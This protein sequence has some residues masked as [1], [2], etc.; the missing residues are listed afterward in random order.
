MRPGQQGLIHLEWTQLPLVP[1]L[2]CQWRNFTSCSEWVRVSCVIRHARSWV[3]KHFHVEFIPAPLPFC[4]G[5]SLWSYYWSS[6]N[7]IEPKGTDVRAV[8][9]IHNARVS[10]ELN[11]TPLSSNEWDYVL[12]RRHSYSLYGLHC[13]SLSPHTFL[14]LF[15]Q[16]KLFASLRKISGEH[17]IVIF[18]KKMYWHFSKYI[19]WEDSKQCLQKHFQSPQA[20]AEIS[21]LGR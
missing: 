14:V 15:S 1:S 17:H 7:L 6:L 16:F 13:S 18:F 11:E 20:L 21:G 9:K 12:H 4:N 10:L 19:S 5:G 8:A 2:N 3:V